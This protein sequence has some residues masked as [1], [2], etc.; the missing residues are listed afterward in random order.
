MD[1]DRSF[2]VAVTGVSARFPGAVD[3][4]DWWSLLLAGRVLTTRLDRQQLLDAGV[5]QSLVDDP[6]YVPVRG[7]LDD[8][9]RFDSKLFR[10][11]PRDAEMMDPQHRL[12]LE[13]AWLAI[14]DAGLNPARVGP[15]TAVFAS[16]SD[17][18]YLRSLVASGPLD[19]ATLDQAIHGNEPDFIA[20]LISYKLGLTGPAMAVQTACSSGLVAVHLA[21]QALFN[22]DCDQALV[23][24]ACVDFPQAGYLPMPG[25]IQSVSGACRPFDASAD[26]VVA[27]SGVAGVVLRRLADVT[28]DG[29]EP[30]GVILGTAV[31]NDGSAKAGYY[32]PSAV[33][34]QNVI[35]A[36]Y[37][38]ADIDATSVGYLETHGTGTRIGDPIEWSAA[39]AALAAMG[40]GPGQVAVGA[41]KANIGH[42]D[43]AAGLTALIKTLLVVK[44]GMVPPVAGFSRP[45]PLL[46]T[47]SSPLFVPAEAMPWAGP[48][49]RR[50]GISSFGIGG[51]NAHVLVE[52]PPGPA[53]TR[54]SA[55]S[56]LVLLSAGDRE[57]LARDA[58]R[59]SDHLASRNVDLADVSFT[60]AT[61]RAALPE[62][63]AVVGRT[64]AEVAARLPSGVPGSRPA[65]ACAPAVFLFPGQGTQSPGMAAPL[66][67][68]LPGFAAAL[69]SCL[70]AFGAALAARLRSALLDPEFPA[71]ELQA[72]ELAQ[73]ALFAVEHA[74]YVAL[75][76]LGVTPAAVAGHSL[77]EITAAAVSGV[78]DLP[79]AARL[80]TV[81]G[82]VMQACAEGAML[83]VGC[84]EAVTLALAAE[85]GADLE[86]AAVN[87]PDNCVVAGTAEAV[88]A[89]QSWLAGRVFARRL[90]TNRA[91]HSALIEP[92]VAALTAELSRIV[93]GRPAVPF[94]MNSTGRLLPAGSEFSREMFTEQAR[95]PVRFGAALA[96]LAAR[97]PG[98]VAVEIGPGH[99]LSQMAEAAGLTAVPLSPARTPCPDEEI[100]AALGALWTVGQP[101]DVAA[102]CDG[103][104][105]VHLPGYAFAG[106]R[107]IA[108]EVLAGTG[109]ATRER[110][111]AA[112]PEAAHGTAT[113]GTAR[114]QPEA[115]APEAVQGADVGPGGEPPQAAAPETSE[116]LARLWAEVLGCGELTDDSDFFELGGDSLLITHLAHRVN[117]ELGIKVPLRDMLAV[118]TL[119]KQASIVRELAQPMAPHDHGRAGS[120]ACGSRGRDAVPMISEG[121]PHNA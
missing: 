61:G 19:P 21:V 14:E 120:S 66:A 81:R 67:E 1:R 108:P 60:L 69:E 37:R 38:A 103:G 48:L 39:S 12:M 102:L 91:F 98:A 10:V 11:S 63:M 117:H 9:D 43:A 110:V 46:E 83:M 109:R 24:A 118:R 7:F 89:F 116:L 114:E 87:G 34:Q 25:G 31:N 18:G 90:R 71:E 112:S 40:A 27:G 77:G 93:V 99:A 29:P 121:T 62:R 82:R 3:L 54:R 119:G 23:V 113:P 74:A 53:V 96:A 16:G 22:G 26:G 100:L 73:P 72:T 56:R 75:A 6:G 97:F 20:S 79:T 84:D 55:G 17:R 13:A 32:A 51:T 52:Q 36:A 104:S 86:L 88:E 80:V 2:D 115:T 94:A 101:V 33:G 106:P 58:S 68:V 42:L 92:A 78:L 64:S 44:H 70:A 4:D 28:S 50:G 5:P 76:G 107:W 15:V 65:S 95:R 45:N 8:V 41:V 49:P 105:L 111:T 59:L 57:A 85:S 30:Y 35:Q 47:G